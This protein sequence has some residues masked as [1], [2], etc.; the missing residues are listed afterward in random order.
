MNNNKAQITFRAITLLSFELQSSRSV[1]LNRND[2]PDQM[3]ATRASREGSE[4][5]LVLTKI[6][7][8]KNKKRGVR[9]DGSPPG[10][11]IHSPL[12]KLQDACL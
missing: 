3:A 10:G 12:S 11:V 9:G 1:I 6:H 2:E 4:T 5:E 7:Q 8:N